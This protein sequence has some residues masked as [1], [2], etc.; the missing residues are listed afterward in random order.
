MPNP[1]VTNIEGTSSDKCSGITWLEYWRRE[2]GGTRTTCTRLGCPRPAE[3]G[4]HV[5][6]VDKRRSQAPH[7]VP[8]CKSC[9]RKNPDFIIELDKRTRIVPAFCKR[10]GSK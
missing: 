4:A 2:S 7:I 3:V 5:R 10:K 8:L 1:K 9:N 6:Y